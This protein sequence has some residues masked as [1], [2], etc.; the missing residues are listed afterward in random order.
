VASRS[1]TSAALLLAAALLLPPPLAAALLPPPP[2]AAALL[3]PPP[4]AAATLFIGGDARDDRA[5]V[6]PWAIAE[7]KKAG[8]GAF[9]F[10]G[11]MELT[12]SLDSLF[13]R[14]L[15]ELPMPF[16]PVIGNHEVLSLGVLGL[17]ERHNEKRFHQLFLGTERTKVTSQMD[18]RVIYGVA[19][20]GK[21][22]LL[23]VDN[24]SG[25]GF[26]ERQ[27]AL[28]KED[29]DAAAAARQRGE[30]RYLIVGMHKALAKN[31]V[32][33]HAMDEDGAQAI[34][35]S[36]AAERLFREHGVDLIFA[37][38]DHL[39]AKIEARRCQPAAPGCTPV[40]ETHLTGGLGAP[41]DRRKKPGASAIHHVLR[42]EVDPPGRPGLQVELVPFPDPKK[43]RYAPPG[44]DG[45]HD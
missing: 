33:T 15:T 8:A 9:V 42:L 36:E 30:V 14:E 12:S 21:V 22:Y 31:G 6:M 27:L 2:L 37:S 34:A 17:H 10:L 1:S 45:D 24:V 25:K 13:L 20:P 26:G 7:A 11:D 35:D 28:M 3:L 5:K 40:I 44:K 41:L 4:L 32:T 29:L 43:A 19:L 16:Y 39:Y 23:A 18:D 38:H